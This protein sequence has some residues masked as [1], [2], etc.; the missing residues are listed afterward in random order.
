RTAEI[1][2]RVQQAVRGII[3]PAELGTMVDN[4]GLSSSGI[5][6]AYNNT[7]TIGSQDGGIQIT[8]NEGHGP[9][10]DY[11]RRMRE[12]LPRRFPGVTISFPPADIIS[13]ILNFGS[14]APIDLQVRGN[15]LAANFDY[16]NTLLREIRRVPGVVDARI[17]QSQQSPAFSV[18]VDRTRAQLLGIT[19]RD[20][21]N[22]LVVNLAGSSQVAP[23]YW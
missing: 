2:A 14:P 21:T 11:V 3:P 17:Q 15:N 9:T 5:N 22:S 18:D 16:T 6:T 7:G 12:E 23:T 10:A 19:E 8:L 20:V 1:L 13:Q 4:M